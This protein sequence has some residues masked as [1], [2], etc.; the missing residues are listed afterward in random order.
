[1][2]TTF[3]RYLTIS[4]LFLIS[5]LIFP[6]QKQKTEANSDLVEYTNKEGLPTTNISKIVQTKD[7]FI[8]ISGI[9]GTYRF[10][11]YEFEEIGKEYGLPQMQNMYYD[12]TKNLLYFASPKKFITFNGKEFKA[13]SEKD[14]YSINGL[15]GQVISFMNADSKGRVWIGSSTPYIDKNFN[16]GLTKFEN[17]KFTVYNSSNFP[18]DN[19]TNFIETPYGDL[20][21]SSDGRNTQTKEGSYIALYKNGIFKKIDESA[22]IKL[23][24]AT[25]L[26]E[27]IS[28][29]IDKDG[30]TWLA[31][32]GIIKSPVADKNIA[33]ALMYDGSQF[34]QYTDFVD[35]LG[36]NINPYQVYYS[37]Q[38]DKVL[39]TTI[40]MTSYLELFT[41][42]NNSVYE[43]NNGK[44]E[45]SNIIQNIKNITDL[46]TGKIINDFHYS[47]VVFTNKNK[48]FPELLIFQNRQEGISSKYPDQ[49]FT[50]K[51]GNWLKY[52]AYMADV[53]GETNDGLIMNNPSKGFGIYYPNFSKLLT[54][55]DGLLKLLGMNTGNLYT[56]KNGIVWIWDSNS[57]DPAYAE[58]HNTGINIWDGKEL[59]AYTEKDGLL[60]D[61]TFDTFQDSKMRVWIPTSKGLTTTLEIKNSKGEQLLKF[62]NIESDLRKYYN[63]T[64]VRETKQGEIYT[65]QNY[66]RPES[67]D[68]IK[69]DFYLGKFNGEKFVEIKSPFSDE[70]NN[71]KYQLFDLREDNEGRLWFIGLFS[72]NLK[73][74][75]SIN[76]QI[77]IYDGKTWHQLPQNWNIPNE[78]LHYV[79]ILKNGMY[80]LAV[81]GFYVFNGNRFVNLSDSVNTNADFR[82]LKGASVAGTMTNIQAGDKL[83]IRLRNRVLVIFDGTHL[84]FYT[85]K[86]GLPLTNIFSPIVDM[87]GNVFFNFPS[88]ALVVRGDKFQTYYDDE[89][90]VTGGPYGSIMDGNGDLVEL[91]SGVGLYINKTENSSYPLKISSVIVNKQYYYYKYPEELTYS[92]NSFVFNYAALNYR[93]P[94]QT[95]YEHLLEGF[96]KEWSR[97]STLP[98]VEYQN[99][100]PGKYRFRVKA[101]TSN[102][103]KTNEEFYSFTINPPW[104]QTIFAYIGYFFAFV[105]IV[106]GIN[107]VERRR[108]VTKERNAAA[109]KEANLRAQLAE[110]ENE[111]KTKELEEA[112][113]LQLS[114]L[115]KELPQLPHL[116]IAVYMKTATEVGG[117]YYDFHVGMDGT[118]T[119]VIGDATGYGMKAGTMVTT[120]KSLFSSHAGNP[121]I[122]FTFQEITRCIKYMNMHMLSMCLSILKI[123][124]NKMQISAAGMPPALLYRSKTKTIEE[125]ILKGMPLGAVQDFPYELRQTEIYPGDTLLLMSDG[126]PELFNRDKEMFG[127][128]RVMEIYKKVA[129]NNPEEIIEKLKN[130]GADWV[131]NEAPDDDV[132]FVVIKVK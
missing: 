112:R 20:I 126:F 52:D 43:F 116:D 56:D 132:T 29:S 26:P 62:K 78:Q 71:K 24:N 12:S 109:I 14:G 17:G 11:G 117:D 23:Q 105:G 40:S 67:K 98:F 90:I 73:D 96:D 44:W 1:M 108:I 94:H 84:N 92:Q 125:I 89:N 124:G 47:R 51:N 81:G 104:W 66:V 42:K 53:K 129:S 127:Y 5:S 33:G 16:G 37:Q 100:P 88:G 31:F 21:F 107:R 6:Q 36:K 120:T 83:Y 70:D 27:N 79:G 121:D 118:L 102:G 119:V 41:G 59:R 22:G 68:F 111:R 25:I 35:D 80:F 122:L 113:Q 65:W 85:K 64:S 75:T 123:Q 54:R 49:I 86:E 95:T 15:S 39:L 101:I 63:A 131:N 99:L 60:S 103:M 18:L 114:M 7:G 13:Y 76:S 91:Y 106:F 97:S 30:N 4:F 93:N 58:I 2:T 82:I 72:D 28:T 38:M 77:M 57:D 87:K 8:W 61:I 55:K 110:A 46:K 50:N 9:E 48:F 32:S 3:L 10:N 19:A 115:P 34:H 128:E 45:P 130:I 69:A 74:L